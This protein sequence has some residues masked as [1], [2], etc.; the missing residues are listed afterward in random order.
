MGGYG[1]LRTFHEQPK[2]FKAV[3][4]FSGHPNLLNSW[5]DTTVYPNILSGQYLA[6]FKNTPVFISPR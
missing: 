6:S 5:Q 3:A 1:A 4:V 2:L